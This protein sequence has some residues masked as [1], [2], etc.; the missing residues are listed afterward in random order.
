MIIIKKNTARRTP[1]TVH[2]IMIISKG[3]N[4]NS[5]VITIEVFTNVIAVVR[6]VEEKENVVVLY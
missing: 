2:K 5:V 1:E 6:N 3:I 4:Q